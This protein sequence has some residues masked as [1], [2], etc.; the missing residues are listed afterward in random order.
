MFLPRS[1]LPCGSLRIDL[2]SV[3]AFFFLM[4][5]AGGCGTRTP[6]AMKTYPVSGQIKI[7]GKIPSRAEIRF[8]P[9]KPLEDPLK[10]SIEPYAIV[11]EDGS[12]RVSTYGDADGAPAGDYA[13]TV[14]WPKVTVEG[15]EETYGSDQLGNK[16]SDPRKPVTN[17]KVIEGDN[18]IPE[19]AIKY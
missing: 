11:K 19:I 4:T 5:L 10:R 17:I 14:V 2:L 3:T 13:V 9:A 15:G 7:N 16:F 8:K 12:F 1:I 6:T 18:V